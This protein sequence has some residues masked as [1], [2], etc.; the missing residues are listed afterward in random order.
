VRCLE[1]ERVYEREGKK[2]RGGDGPEDKEEEDK[3]E[4]RLFTNNE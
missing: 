1:R 2:E 3:E 4:E